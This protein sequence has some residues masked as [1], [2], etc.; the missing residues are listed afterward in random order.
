METIEPLNINLSDVPQHSDI[1]E[2]GEEVKSEAAIDTIKTLGRQLILQESIS[3]NK[4]MS[5]KVH[6]I[7]SKHDI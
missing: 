7:G 2:I 1:S 6:D 4:H 3:R 5:N